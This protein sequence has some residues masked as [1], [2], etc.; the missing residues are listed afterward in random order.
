MNE[1]LSILVE[2]LKQSNISLNFKIIEVGALKIQ[3]QDEPFYEL[4]DYFPSTKIIGFEIEKEIC[5]KMNS[6]AKEG[7]KYYSHALGKDNE[8][9]KFY[10]TQNPMCSSLYKPNEE[11][12][13]LYNNFEVAYLKKETEIET[14]SLDY[15]V[16]KHEVGDIDFIK[17]DVQGAELDVFKGGSKTLKNVL[18]IVCEVEFIQHYENQPLFGEVS[19][20]LSQYNLM[21]NKFLGLSGRALKPIMLNNNP[22]LPSQHI[23]SDAVFVRHIQ[24]IHS[25]NDEKLLKL[26]LLACVYYSLDLTFYCLSEYDKRHS[27]SFA[28]NWM[29]K[30]ANKK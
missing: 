4:L 13:K 14:I 11:L 18:K 19:D 26:G 25:L 8:Q 1:A 28:K 16:E 23:W 12:I 27:T 15:F 9:R 21:F 7:V 2:L 3:D 20:Y 24:K 5:E 29:S 17:I 10:I 22:N 6:Q 30:I